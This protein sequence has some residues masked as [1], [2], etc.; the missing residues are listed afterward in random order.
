MLLTLD[1]YITITVFKTLGPF[2]WEHVRDLPGIPYQYP[3]KYY[4]Y[5]IIPVQQNKIP[6]VVFKVYGN[7]GKKKNVKI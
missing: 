1:I 2:S 3:S 7:F 5:L 4:M 6:R